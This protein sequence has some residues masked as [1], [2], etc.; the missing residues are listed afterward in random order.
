MT[1]R[2]ETITGGVAGGLRAGAIWVDT[3]QG[4]VDRRAGSH[5]QGSVCDTELG[6][7]SSAESL[8]G[9]GGLGRQ[10]RDGADGATA[11]GGVGSPAAGISAG[12]YHGDHRRHR[13][14]V[15]GGLCARQWVQRGW[16]ARI[17]LWHRYAAWPDVFA[18]ARGATGIPQWD[19]S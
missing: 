9:H 17:R 16:L 8:A 15:G 3:L 14:V 18:Y 4:R 12:Q 5:W 11:A 19:R 6:A 10:Q 7:Q 13:G 2:D 1:G